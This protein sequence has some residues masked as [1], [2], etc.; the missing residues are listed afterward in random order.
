M[1]SFPSQ[2]AIRFGILW[3]PDIH[4][5]APEVN[6]TILDQRVVNRQPYI[7]DGFD[8]VRLQTFDLVAVRGKPGATFQSN[9]VSRAAPTDSVRT[10]SVRVCFS[11]TKIDLPS[12]FSVKGRQALAHH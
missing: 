2:I 9:W 4:A 7:R 8:Q 1:D 12:W 5:P 10:H 3:K 6:G 11:L